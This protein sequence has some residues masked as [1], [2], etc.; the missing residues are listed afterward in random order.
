MTGDTIEHSSAN[1]A[2]G[3]PPPSLGAPG[4]LQSRLGGLAIHDG[5]G[6]PDYQQQQ[7]QHLLGNEQVHTWNISYPKCF[8]NREGVGEA[9]PGWGER[10][11]F[12]GY[13]RFEGGTRTSTPTFSCSCAALLLFL[14]VERHA[15]CPSCSNLCIER[16][17]D[18][19][20]CGCKC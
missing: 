16:P 14:R 12:W 11:R 1:G 5:Q 2:L 19:R 3:L 10:L 15:A 8:A 9:W 20:V 18:C 4:S 17:R 6:F 7:Q 13:V